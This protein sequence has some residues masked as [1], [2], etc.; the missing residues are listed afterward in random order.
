MSLKL[1]SYTLALLA[2]SA[3]LVAF[4]TSPARGEVVT[5]AAKPCMRTKFET[6]LIKSACKD[7][8]KAARKAMKGFVKD[9]RKA[10]KAAGDSDFDITCQD[11][12]SKLNPAFELES[13]GLAKFKELAPLI[14]AK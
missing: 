6:S 13:H 5:A 9:I 11:C 1:A 2:V 10:K 12:H 7:G 4:D 3:M 14:G 8:Q